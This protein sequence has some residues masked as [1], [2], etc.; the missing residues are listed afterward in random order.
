M[1]GAL[2]LFSSPVPNLSI[3]AVFCRRDGDGEL[4]VG[5]TWTDAVGRQKR[6]GRRGCEGLI[7]Q[8]SLSYCNLVRLVVH[9][10]RHGV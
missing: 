4:F 9:F 6:G 10:P 5:Q 3:C 1:Y 8:H 7:S 2:F